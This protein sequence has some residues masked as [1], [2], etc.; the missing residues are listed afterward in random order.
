MYDKDIKIKDLSE[1]EKLIIGSSVNFFY[2]LLLQQ[3]A[4][5]ENNDSNLLDLLSKDQKAQE[6]YILLQN[7]KNA[8]KK[9]AEIMAS[10]LDDLVD[11]QIDALARPNY[12]FEQFFTSI[13]DTLMGQRHSED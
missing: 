5:I 9:I 11:D 10:A 2:N 8:S 3:L 7:T 6:D 1:I 4:H 13:F 12:L